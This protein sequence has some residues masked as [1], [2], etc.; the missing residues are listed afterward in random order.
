MFKAS[1]ANVRVI[2]RVGVDLDGNPSSVFEV[3]RVRPT[4]KPQPKSVLI[5][6][7][8]LIEYKRVLQITHK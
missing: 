4:C 2:F 8:P 1:L 5:T 6:A 3:V 7:V